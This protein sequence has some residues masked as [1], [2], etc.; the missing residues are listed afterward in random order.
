MLFLCTGMRSGVFSADSI[1]PRSNHLFV[2]GNSP[3]S[4]LAVRYGVEDPRWTVVRFNNFALGRGLG[5]RTDVHVVN[6]ETVL[7]RYSVPL[8][9]HMWSASAYR[10]W[11]PPFVS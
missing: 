6:K 5:N 11:F 1:L 2:V 7:G 4:E 10:E 8:T 3:S 9:L